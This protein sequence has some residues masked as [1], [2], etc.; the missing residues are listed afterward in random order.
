MN[1]LS[2][3]YF[4]R[5]ISN[6]ERIMGM[7]LPDL[8]KNANKEWS[9]RPEKA[10][11]K[12]SADKNLY[13]I[14]EGWKRHLEV[15]RYFHSSDFFCLHTQN[16]KALIHPVLVNTEVRPSFVAHIALELMLDSILL[17]EGIIT[18]ERFY[19]FLS[20]TD[21]NSLDRFLTLNNIIDTKPFFLFLEEFISSAY[22][23]SYKD[24]VHIVYALGRICMRLW[25]NPFTET[26]KLQLT[27]VLVPYLEN[28]RNDYMTIFDQI[29]SKL[30][31]YTGS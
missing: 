1:F 22:L 30:N 20:R 23:G 14:Y 28:L 15:D 12:F 5:S 9:L 27:A 25:V 8:V 6:P 10:P 7:V 16:I 31:P 19:H 11:E 4:D 2:H 13:H 29:E 18:T 26:Q 21:K 17:T 3:F 24:S